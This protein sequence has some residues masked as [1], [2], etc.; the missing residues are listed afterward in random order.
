MDQLR[1]VQQN[2]DEI[3][4]YILDRVTL[5][6]KTIEQESNTTTIFR[7]QGQIEE[8]RRLQRAM[9]VRVDGD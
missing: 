3:V 2:Y 5:L 6:H 7:V 8:L 9:Q 1:L 4:Q